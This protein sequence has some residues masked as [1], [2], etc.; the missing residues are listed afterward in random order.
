MTTP[1]TDLS[2]ALQD[3]ETALTMVL[4]LDDGRDGDLMRMLK[5]CVD[6]A[7]RSLDRSMSIV[8]ALVSISRAY[9]DGYAKAK[10]L[11]FTDA[12]FQCLDHNAMVRAAMGLHE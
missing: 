10:H 5:D 4:A 8:L 9:I 6:P 1:N 3:M 11:S 2:S 7:Q 12:L